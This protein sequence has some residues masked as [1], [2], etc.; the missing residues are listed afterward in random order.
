VADEAVGYL[1]A[2]SALIDLRLSCGIW[3][4]SDWKH[5]TVFVFGNTVSLGMGR[6]S[7]LRLYHPLRWQR[8]HD[9]IVLLMN[10]DYEQPDARVRLMC[11]AKVQRHINALN[12]KPQ[13]KTRDKK[14]QKSETKTN[15][16]TGGSEDLKNAAS[17]LNL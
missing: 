6:T 14:I 12:C 9:G 5:S 16:H 7:G 8:F 1:S 3:K 15:V 17:V 13:S 4:H 2:A 10:E 11:V